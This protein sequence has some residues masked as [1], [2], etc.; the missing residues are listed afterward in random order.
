MHRVKLFCMTKNRCVSSSILSCVLPL[1]ATVIMSPR[2]YLPA[3]VLL[4][5]THNI[6]FRLHAVPRGFVAQSVALLAIFFFVFTRFPIFLG[7]KT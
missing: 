5:E 7:I 1:W 3:D 2:I 4:T 6:R